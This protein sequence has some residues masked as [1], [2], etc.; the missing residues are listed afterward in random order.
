TADVTVNGTGSVTGGA[1]GVQINAGSGGGGVGIF[2]SAKV[3]VATGG[4]VTGGAGG[5]INQNFAGGGGGMGVVLLPGGALVNSGTIVGGAGGT[6]GL[7]GGGGDGGAGVLLTA[8]GIV[9]NAAGGS[10]TGGVG[11]NGRYNALGP[12]LAGLG[13]AGVT[14]ANITLIN[15]GAITGAMGGTASGAGAPAAVRAAAVQFT[16][17]VNSLE[18]QAGSTIL[19]NVIAFSAADTLRLGGATNA[20]FDVSA[21]GPAAQYRGF[22]IYE[23]TGSSTWTLTGTTPALT[24]WT[25]TGGKLSIAQDGSLGDSAGVLTFNGGTLLTTVSFTMNRA[26]TLNASSGT[27]ETAPA[28]TL[29]VAGVVGGAG[30]LTKTGGGTLELT[31]I[32]SYTGVTTI[33]SGTLALSG[34]GS[35]ANSQRVHA[36]STFDISATASGASIKSLS[37]SG[38]VDLGARTLTLTNAFSTFAGT[39]QGT[40]G[41]TVG[42]GTQTLSGVNT[43]SGATTVSGGTLAAG[44]TN[45]FSAASATAVSAGGTLDLRGYNQTLLSLNNAGLVGLGGAPGTTLTIAGDYIGN[46]GTLALNTALGGD[47]SA[48]D[49][50]VVNGNTSGT[51]NVRVTNIGGNGAQTSEGI[52]IIDVAGASNGTFSLLGD[53]V[54]YGQQAVIGGAYAYT[55][56]KNGIANPADGDWYLRSSLVNPPPAAP[57]GPIYQ[58]GVPLYEVHSQVLLALNTL[59]TLQQRAGNRYWEVDAIHTGAAPSVDQAGAGQS[60]VWGRTEG[61]YTKAA[62][63][64]SMTVSDYNIGQWKARTGVDGRLYQ[65]DAGMLIGGI[66]AHYGQAIAEVR[67]KYGDGR[68]N[69]TGGGIGGTLTWYGANGFYVDGQAQATFFDSDLKSNLVSR[70]MASGVGA[71]GYA[72]SLETG[73]RFGIDGPWALTPQAQLVYSAVNSDFQDNFGARVSPGRSDSLTGRLGLALDHQKIWRDEAGKLTRANVYGITNVYYEFLGDTH[74]DVSGTNFITG[75]EKLAAGFG[76]GGTYNWDNDRYSVYGEALV[77]TRFNENY[78]VGGTGGFRMKW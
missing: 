33:S 12:T 56:Q 6:G 68:I 47:A 32:N 42:G 25:L 36:D 51:S 34:S 40:G 1:G 22:G 60:V 64:G 29:T 63:A 43:Y 62:P 23:K 75:R 78:S 8:G 59:P 54:Y 57:S 11:G 48:T 15:A 76:V 70:N 37:G 41:L 35:I 27:F 9:T 21:I 50:L 71:F 5:G 19:G 69:T 4:R 18:I 2:S 17:G 65:S 39:I 30:G 26:V 53:Y 67:S 7:I 66:T 49:R 46:G 58:P 31:A 24:P 61:A 3:T 73:K 45:A 38:F 13:G 44:A 16:G 72:L 55:L 14:G 28:T 10:I 74:V 52:K 77:K 20:S